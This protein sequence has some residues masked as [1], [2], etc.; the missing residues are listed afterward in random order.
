MSDTLATISFRANLL[1]RCNKCIKTSTQNFARWESLIDAV[2]SVQLDASQRELLNSARLAGLVTIVESVLNDILVEA[3]VAYPGKLCK[4]QVTVQELNNTGSCLAT[5]MLVAQKTANDMA[6][7]NFKEYLKVWQDYVGELSSLSENHI[8]DFAE[9]KATRDVYVHNNGK[10]NEIY[11]R[12]AGI[13]TRQTDT[14]GKLPIDDRYLQGA[15]ALSASIMD[16]VSTT[17]ESHY[18]NCTKET[19]FREMWEATC[20]G[21]MVPFDQQWEVSTHPYHRKEFNWL[22]SHSEKALFDVFLRIFHT[23]SPD[24]T[25][26]IQYALYRWS[27]DTAEGQVIRSWIEDPFYL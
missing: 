4:K 12:K 5:F 17:I 14:N 9:I 16:A 3:L 8:G 24:I 20:C 15:S 11:E 7:L 13:K 1:L 26:D 25:T 6:Y 22:W 18:G 10:P 2:K 21:E 23:Q 27:P 19:I